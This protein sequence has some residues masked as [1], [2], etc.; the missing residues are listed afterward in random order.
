M[1]E[2][3][4]I[5]LFLDRGF[6]I[7]K[8][9]LPLVIE[10]PEIILN[11]LN[12][13][14]PRP[15]IVTSNQVKKV[16]KELDLRKKEKPD[17]KLVSTFDFDKNPVSIEDYSKKFLSLFEN[18]KSQLTANTELGK[19]I[20]INKISPK[21]SEFSVIGMVR[22][23][24]SNNI[25]LEDS[26][27]EIDIYFNALLQ[28]KYDEI[29]LDDVI[30]VKC[31]KI[32]VK[33]NAL[34]VIYPDVPIK[35]EI[36]KSKKDI[37]LIFISEAISSTI[38]TNIENFVGQK[39]MHAVVFSFSQLSSEILQG[40]QEI[41]Y[42]DI[43]SLLEIDGVKLMIIPKQFFEPNINSLSIF[44]FLKKKMIFGLKSKIFKNLFIE[45]IPDI[46]YTNLEPPIYKNY[47]GTTVISNTSNNEVYII[48]LKT[49]E[50]SKKQI[51]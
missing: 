11:G 28:K 26:T 25:I 18:I 5:K 4:V 13:L 36:K 32:D 39:D 19:L 29:E 42:N 22:E 6:Q 35:R 7:S 33:F 15:F 8:E 48:N 46:I 37:N 1:E 21:T 40:F 44:Y 3:E 24:R 14:Q 16:F 47:K 2:K 49:R 23:K 17:I 12:T 10:D 38:P 34:T 31:K 27:G 43:I 41:K 45:H 51:S 20:S 30:G 9:A 50:V